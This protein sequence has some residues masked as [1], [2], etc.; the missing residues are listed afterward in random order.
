VLVPNAVNGHMSL[1]RYAWASP[2][3]VIGLLFVP[4]VLFT[5]GGVQVVDGVLELYGPFIAWVLRHCVPLRGG[6][7]AM[8]LGHVVLGRDRRSLSL[9]RAHEKVHVRQCELWGPAFIP[10]YFAAAL[11]GLM[12]RTGMYHGNF[13]ERQAIGCERSEPRAATTRS[14]DQYPGVRSH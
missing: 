5:K 4:I 13:F 8:T 11:W 7:W 1:T 2:N 3:T 6:A 14:V 9:T 10:A 12:T